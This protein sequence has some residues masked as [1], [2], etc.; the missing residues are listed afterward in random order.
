[1]RERPRPAQALSQVPAATCKPMNA[2]IDKRSHRAAQTYGELRCPGRPKQVLA[3]E[4]D[5]VTNA[6]AEWRSIHS[7]EQRRTPTGQGVVVGLAERTKVGMFAFEARP[8]VMKGVVRVDPRS[9]RMPGWQ[10]CYPAEDAIKPSGTDKRTMGGVMASD[11]HRSDRKG[12]QGGS[13]D[14]SRPARGDAHP[15]ER[16]DVHGRADA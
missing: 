10:H 16:G 5:D 4:L 6:D 8:P 3:I 9:K 15:H 14:D 1:M 7:F 2:R 13:A 12:V 11:K